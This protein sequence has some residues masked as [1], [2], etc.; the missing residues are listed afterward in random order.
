MNS[1]HGGRLLMS[2]ARPSKL[3]YQVTEAVSQQI[4]DRELTLVGSQTQ[5]TSRFFSLVENEVIPSQSPAPMFPCIQALTETYV[6]MYIFRP[7][8]TLSRYLVRSLVQAGRRRLSFW[9]KISQ[10]ACTR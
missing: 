5:V 7:L 6:R 10:V 8:S 4:T 2:V 1:I 3:R 9:S